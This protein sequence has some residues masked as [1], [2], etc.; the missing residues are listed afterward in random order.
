VTGKW[1]LEKGHFAH[2]FMITGEFLAGQLLY[3]LLGIVHLLS[4]Q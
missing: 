3:H 2:V 4:S 1:D